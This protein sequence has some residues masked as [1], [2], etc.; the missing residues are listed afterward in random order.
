MYAIHESSISI[1]FW[2]YTS[3]EIS[4]HSNLYLAQKP[5]VPSQLKR[6]RVRGQELQNILID[7]IVI[8]LNLSLLLL[9][10]IFLIFVSQ[11]EKQSKFQVHARMVSL[12]LP[13][14][15]IAML[16]NLLEIEGPL[17]K[18][19]NSLKNIIKRKGPAASKVKEGLHEL[20]VITSHIE[21]FGLKVF[22]NLCR[23]RHDTRCTVLCTVLIVL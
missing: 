22:L 6:W 18:V 20:E 19:S 11:S 1:G 13:D 17:D 3:S 14:H 10:F 7:K 8:D 21:A 23:N 2:Y 4:V 15:F 12:G 9:L 5:L 16:F